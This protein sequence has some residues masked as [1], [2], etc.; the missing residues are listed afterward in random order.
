MT[1]DEATALYRLFDGSGILLYAGISNEPP[2]R[3]REHACS[4]S[5]WSDVQTKTVEW[6]DSRAAAGVAESTAVESERPIY[7]CTLP[8]RDGSPSYRLLVPKPRKGVTPT[9]TFSSPDDLWERFA[10]AVRNSPDPEADMSKVLRQFCRWYVGDPGA[11]L[12][13]RPTDATGQ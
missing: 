1:P 9:R 3:W 13:K 8:A 12:P 11:E 6:F 5:W 4:E 2:R 10:D 7:N